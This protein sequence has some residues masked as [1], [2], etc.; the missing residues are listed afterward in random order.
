MI[1]LYNVIIITLRCY[2]KFSR[3]KLFLHS[4]LNSDTICEEDDGGEAEEEQNWMIM[5]VMVVDK[6]GAGVV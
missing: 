4:Q 6:D 2:I 3:P 1:L 5:M